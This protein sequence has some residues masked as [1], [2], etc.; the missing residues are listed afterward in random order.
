MASFS[1]RFLDRSSVLLSVLLGLCT[2]TPAGAGAQENLSE[3][4][5]AA[6]R[7]AVVVAKS[8][9]RSVW[10]GY[11][12]PKEFVVCTEGGGSVMALMEPPPGDVS[13]REVRGLPGERVT[14][15][16]SSATL[17]GLRDVCIDLHYGLQ[18]RSMLAFPQL[19]STFSVTDPVAAL[20]TV[21][22]HEEFHR[23]QWN[24]FR[25]TNGP[26]GYAAVQKPVPVPRNVVFSERFR[27]LAAAERSVLAHAV[28]QHDGDSI[29][30]SLATYV[31]IRKQR[32]AL[33]P[34]PYRGT[35]PHEERKEGSAHLVAYQALNAS[36]ECCGR[37]VRELIHRDL[38]T[39]APFVRDTVTSSYRHWHIY[40]T[41]AAIGLILDR[42]A[43]EW[44]SR[45]EGGATFFQLAQEAAADGFPITSENEPQ[46][47]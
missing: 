23:Y 32:R 24:S 14:V 41:G 36:L 18:G 13:W 4:D 2:A 33:L 21:L 11:T 26:E 9:V 27:Q 15:Y 30:S 20:A 8:D 31:R 10:P 45:L 38:L 3:G 16:H 29:R 40:A 46:E 22:Y 42:L 17:P 19:D 7:A 25:Q 37:S 1:G 44:R 39:T 5:S 43:M 28:L 35:E 12:G 34:E 47:R 6:V